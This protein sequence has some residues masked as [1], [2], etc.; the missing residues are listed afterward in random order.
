MKLGLVQMKMTD[1]S[2]RNLDTAAQMTKD[3][4]RNGAQIVCFP[5]LFTSLY[6][7]QKEKAEA[8]PETIPGRTTRVLSKMAKENGVVLVAGSLYEQSRGHMYNTAVVFD[9]DGRLLG[10]YRKVHIP[11]DESFYEQNYFSPGNQ[12]KV[13]KTR[14]GKI[15]VLI[16]FDQWYPEAAR[17]CRLNGA[18]VIFYPTAIGS[19]KGIQQVE[20]NWQEAWEAVQR[21]HAI[22]NSVVVAT[23][24]R[25]GVEDEMDF[26]GGSFVCDQFGKILFR[27]GDKEGVFVVNCDRS[28]GKEV[29]AGWGFLRNR[30]PRTYR[31]IVRG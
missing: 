11:Q 3:A 20:G 18:E 26:W 21:G 22:A 4:A 12:F 28:L 7:P 8:I 10:K 16:C 25:V 1:D 9:A 14:F 23:V 6:F 13:F 15:A 30:K 5:E 2:A 31:K 29:E 27:A 19:V 17:V 24:N